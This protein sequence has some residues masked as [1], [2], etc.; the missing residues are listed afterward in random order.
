MEGVISMIEDGFILHEWEKEKMDKMVQDNLIELAE[1][2]G[3]T[4]GKE[5]GRVEG[6][7]NNKLEMIKN[8]LEED[9]DFEYIS[10]ISGKTIE[11]I[12]EIEKSLKED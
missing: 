11:E 9:T 4:E 5:E 8:M 3:R 10:K 2:R 6:I 1:E 7:E 12:K